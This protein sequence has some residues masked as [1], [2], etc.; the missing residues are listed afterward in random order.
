[1][2]KI[3]NLKAKA[4][5]LVECLVALVILSGGLL[6]FDGLSKLLSQEVHY[7]SQAKQKDWLVFSQQLRIELEETRLIRVENNRLYVDK[8]GQALA[9]GQLK[10]DDFRKTNDKG[11]GYQPMIYGL[12]SSQISQS[13][14]LIRIDLFFD[15][16]LE[17][18]FLYDF[19]EKP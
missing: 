6:V 16:G 8:N 19:S 9:F 13:G 7:H 18:T 5:T 3:M 1:M 11:Q 14:Q 4:F 15:D 12:T 17:R 2:K 10:S